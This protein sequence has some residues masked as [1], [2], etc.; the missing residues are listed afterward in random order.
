MQARSDAVLAPSTSL[1]SFRTSP[2]SISPPPQQPPPFYIGGV[3]SCV[4]T[5]VSHPFDLTKVRLQTIKKQMRSGSALSASAWWRTAAKHENMLRIM[6][7]ISQTEGLRSLYSGLSASLL[8]QGTY[9]TIRFGLYDK[10]KWLIAGDTKPTFGQLLFCSTAAGIL[11]GAFG[12]PSDV[13]NVRMQNDGQLPP[14]Q[15]RHYKNAIDGLIRICREEG[16][17]VLLRG[18]GYSTTR[19]VVMT[20]SQ[21]TSYDEFKDLFSDKLGYGN[22]L[23]T[24]FGASVS[25]ALVATTMCSPL[26]VIKTRIMSAHNA[27]SRRPISLIIHMATMEGIGSFF[28]GW[29]PAFIRLGP[30]TIVTFLV[31]EQLK[32][33]HA[34]WALNK[35]QIIDTATT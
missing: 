22:G 27:E 32:D 6:W 35:S 33:W 8:R 9:S 24:H 28:K 13:V 21:M 12:N 15:R 26:D 2:S 31:M 7:T 20:V 17:Q 11:G 4:A 10:F 30:H 1:Q 34:Q 19:A 18:L 3:A 14:S 29:L 23:V 25:A 5:F 16:P